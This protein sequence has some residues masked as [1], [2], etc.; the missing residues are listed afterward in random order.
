M[1]LSCGRSGFDPSNNTKIENITHGMIVLGRQLEDPY[2]VKN[3][4][5]A[6]ESLYPTKAQVGTLDP[7]HYYVR[8]RIRSEEQL[9]LLE[10]MNLDYLDHPMD[11][12]IVREG[13]YYHDPS[14][15]EDSITYQYAA[16]PVGTKIPADLEYE[17]LDDVFIITPGATK[18]V[19][20]VD[21]DLVEREAFR[22]TGNEQYLPQTKATPS[23]YPSGRITVVD[24]DFDEEPVGVSGVK[25][26]ANVF[27]KTCKAFTDEEGY[28]TMETS[29]TSDPRYRLVFSNRK[30]FSI[31]LNLILL[32]AS[33]STIG[34]Q[35]SSGFNYTI[36]PRTDETLY[37]RC[38]VNNAV[39]DY[40]EKCKGAGT[41]IK[42]PPANLRLWLIPLFENSAAFMMQQGVITESE[43]VTSFLGD[44]SILAKLFFPDIVVGL[45]NKESYS[46]I[47]A[48]VCH[49]LAHA[50]HFMQVGRVYWE[51]YVEHVISSYLI[52]GGMTYG[53]GTEQNAGYCEIAEMW[54]YYVQ[55]VMNR[56]RYSD[57][58]KVF[59]T[60]YWFSPQILTYLDDRGLNRY[61][62]FPTLSADVHDR[63]TLK[64]RLLSFYPELKSTI[65]QAFN[66]YN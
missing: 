22:I 20:G 16:V 52:S 36:T 56:E 18:A 63:E 50:S 13:D 14:L 31:G 26:C 33:V 61:S 42:T 5:K 6:L 17:R 62:I 65:I 10:Q 45:K 30:G 57:S 9:E 47:Y 49:Q 48:E 7:T 32:K 4:T 53:V 29:F 24:P 21:W 66:R 3:V 46:A 51:K 39:F 37:R 23:Y 60:Q 40:F 27:V 35:S 44:F 25:I 43:L 12:E 19:D 55:T 64:N 41:N 28:F 59:G 8:F 11:Y 58:S 2:S 1:L 34:K 15:P 38:A 54:A